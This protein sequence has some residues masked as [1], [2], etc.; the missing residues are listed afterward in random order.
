MDFAAF[1]LQADGSGEDVAIGGFVEFLAVD[2]HGDGGAIGGNF[3][4]GSPPPVI[5]VG[6]AFLHAHE[7]SQLLAPGFFCG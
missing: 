6:L 2:E 7:I 5:F 3:L 4:G 1:R